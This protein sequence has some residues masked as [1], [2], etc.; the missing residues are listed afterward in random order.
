MQPVSALTTQREIVE[1]YPFLLQLDHCIEIAR[2][3]YMHLEAQV[4]SCPCQ[5]PI[6]IDEVVGVARYK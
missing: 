4:I 5:Q 6:M 2:C 3:G 1:G